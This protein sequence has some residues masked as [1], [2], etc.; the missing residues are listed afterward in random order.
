MSPLDPNVIER[1]LAGDQAAWSDLVDYYAGLVYSIPRKLG[2]PADVCD[3]VAQTVFATLA[4]RLSSVREVSSLAG[5]LA[6]VARR[7]SWRARRAQR[8]GRDE[9][10]P[11]DADV[12]VEDR[13]L[14]R[15]EQILR[16]R[17]L[18][19]GL[20]P[21]CRDLLTALF[22]S[23]TTPSY[24]EIAARLS[25]PLGSIGPTRQRCLAKL[26]SQMQSDAT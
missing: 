16:M 15:V 9:S 11:L 8:R 7:E 24:E 3:D 2:L 1:C 10:G 13:E 22:L 6:T 14:R 19:N 23:E 5:W 21:R 18:L 20:D 17:W 26:A 12:P 25:I 4:R